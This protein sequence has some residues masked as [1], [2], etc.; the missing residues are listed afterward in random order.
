MIN[1][2]LKDLE[3]LVNIDSGSNNVEGVNKV[4]DYF[5]D[6]YIALGWLVKECQY[7]S[8]IGK[9]LEIRNN[10]EENIDVL[11]IGHMDTVFPAGTAKERPF[12]INETR[13]YGP[14]VADMKSGLLTAY[15]AMK[16]IHKSALEKLNICIFYNSDE[17]ISS[18]YSQA[19]IK[20]L[21][22]RSK[23]AFVAEPGRS[24]GSMVMARKGLVKYMVEFKGVAAHA[25]VEPQKGRSAIHEMANWVVDLTKLNN[26]E[27]GTSINFGVVSGGTVANVVADKAYAEIDLRYKIKDEMIKFENRVLQLQENPFITDVK[28]EVHKRGARPPMNPDANTYKLMKTVEDIGKKLDIDIKWSSTGGGSDANFTS[29]L[30][31]PSIDGL[32]P[33]GGG[34]HGVSEYIEIDSIQQS[35]DLLANVLENI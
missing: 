2:F 4:A 12:Y 33:V 8:D 17:E 27:I 34:C 18:A 23:Y 11:I 31:V 20:E 3:Q 5:K 29:E 22:K 26:Y 14:G 32:G 25:G 7:S 30:G 19:R 6:K 13:A 15:Y 10:N 16:S 28:V 1:D 24:D 9:C 35:V 21:A